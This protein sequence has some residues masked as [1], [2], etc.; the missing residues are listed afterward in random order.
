MFSLSKKQG[1]VT[2]R[3]NLPMCFIGLICCLTSLSP[4]HCSC[5]CFLFCPRPHSIPQRLF[6]YLQPHRFHL[7]SPRTGTHT[8]RYLTPPRHPSLSLTSHISSCV[9]VRAEEA[10]YETF[11]CGASPVGPFLFDTCAAHESFASLIPPLLSLVR[12]E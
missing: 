3:R 1:S 11:H 12:D 2:P 8:R 6:L 5:S 4:S 9:F 10:H 7:P